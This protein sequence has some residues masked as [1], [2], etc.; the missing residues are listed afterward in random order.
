LRP[1]AGHAMSPAMN[2][3]ITLAAIVILL[4][5]TVYAG[6]KSGRPRKDSLKPQWISW[7]FVTVLAGALLAF[8]VVHAMNLM[9]I[10]TGQNTVG[11]YGG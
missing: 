4:A 9:G 3:I 5:L 1:G 6:W 11:R 7:P 2:W 8:A 10:Q